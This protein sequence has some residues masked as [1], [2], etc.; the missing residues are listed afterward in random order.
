MSKRVSLNDLAEA[1]GLSKTLVSMVMNGKGD[2]IKISKTT[3]KRVL[4]K[5]KQMNYS[6]NQ[7]A[8]GLRMGRSQTIGLIVPDISNQFYSRIA[9]VMEDEL[10]RHSYRLLICS[11]EELPDKENELI[12]MLQDRAAEGIVLASTQKNSKE[13][14]KLKKDNYPLVLIDREF[15]DEKFDSVSV[16]NR[17]GAAKMTE[18]LLKGGYKKIALFTITPAY[19]SPLSER[20]QGFTDA[21]RKKNLKHPKELLCE[22][23]FNNVEEEVAKQLKKLL[24]PSKKIDAIF[25]LNNNLAVAVLKTLR[26][27]KISIPGDVAVCSFDDIPAFEISYP[28]LTAVA[29]PVDEMGRQAVK[30]ILGRLESKDKERKPLPEYLPVKLMFRESC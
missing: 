14:V 2:T 16:E 21:L 1:L 7:F 10:S 24:L 25:T 13:L 6:P 27:M 20:A 22:I 9:R 29:Q 17:E 23:P 3:Q 18:Q 15:S 8:R 28:P 30:K 11:S 4:E 26:K 5:A 19:I 12:R